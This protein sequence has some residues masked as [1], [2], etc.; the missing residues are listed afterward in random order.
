MSHHLDETIELN[1]STVDCESFKKKGLLP[2]KNK[3][4]YQ[5]NN[6]LAPLHFVLERTPFRQQPF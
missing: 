6:P 4:I 5:A 2:V 1:E 3:C